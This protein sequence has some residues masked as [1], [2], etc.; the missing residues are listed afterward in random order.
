[1]TEPSKESAIFVFEGTVKKTKAANLKAISDTKRTAVVKVGTIR[2]APASLLA[3]VGC[4][5]TIQLAVGERVKA[6]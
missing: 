3:F 2:R 5:V 4:D 1:M 6:G